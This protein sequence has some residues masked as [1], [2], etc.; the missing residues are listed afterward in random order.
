[1]P[2]GISTGIGQS[3]AVQSL[4]YTWDGYG[5][6]EQRCDANR[7]LDEN[8]TDDDLNRLT[9]TTV[10]T[11]VSVS[12]STCAGG[13]TAN[14]LSLGYDA[15]GN[16]QSKSDVGSTY[17]YDPNHPYAVDSVTNSSGITVYSA[18]YDADGN[19]ITRNGSPLTWTVD[20]LPDS[21]AAATGSSTFSYGPEQ[22]RYQQNETYNSVSSTTTYIGSL[23]EVIARPPT[24]STGI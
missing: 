4:I 20:N 13:T 18:S 2:T 24:P 1:M 22:A 19:M 6:L 16:I 15:M 17:K 3:S 7:G 9:G 5:N 23:F 14:T 12:G 10:H 21:L 8:V 11:G